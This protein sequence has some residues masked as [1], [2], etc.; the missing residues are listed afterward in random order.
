MRLILEADAD[1]DQED[2]ERQPQVVERRRGDAEAAIARQ[3]RR[4]RAVQALGA[5]GEI[6]RV[7]RHDRHDLAEAQCHDREVIAP[8]PKRRRAEQHAKA[9]RHHRRD[10]QHAARTT[11][12]SARCRAPVGRQV[13]PRSQ[14]TG[15]APRSCSTPAAPGRR[16]DAVGIGA[17]GEEG[18][19]A[20]VEQTGEAHDDVEARAPAWR[21]RSRSPSRR[22]RRR[23]GASAGRRVAASTSK[24]S[25]RGAA[26]R[27][28]NAAR[29]AGSSGL[30]ERWIASWAWAQ[31]LV[32]A[33]R[34]KS[35]EG[36][37]PAPGPGSRR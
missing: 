2:N 30:V 32:G 3:S 12:R 22:Y 34:P 21:R 17:D 37:T 29:T 4:Q 36:G 20:E 13:L 28:R 14:A 7:A 6:G 35:P 11:P 26:P 15:T 9:R 24:S 10:R 31:D 27:S 33:T 8:Q 5:V 19:I 16:R 23:C 25:R 18:G 1:E